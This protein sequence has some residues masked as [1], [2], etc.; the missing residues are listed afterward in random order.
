MEA[1]GRTASGDRAADLQPEKR[2]GT[3]EE[4]QTR[5]S[6]RCVYRLVGK[7]QHQQRV[8]PDF[9]QKT[10]FS[11]GLKPTANRATVNKPAANE[12]DSP[13]P[14]HRVYQKPYGWRW[15]RQS[16]K[17]GWCGLQG[18]DGRRQPVRPLRTNHVQRMM[19]STQLSFCRSAVKKSQCAVVCAW[20]CIYRPSAAFTDASVS[21]T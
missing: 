2:R 20:L 13:C 18:C 19:A 11:P 6:V 8:F 16:D 15:R 3:N 1:S 5:R 10:D 12:N 17:P 21:S 4:E 14:R 7:P 9:R